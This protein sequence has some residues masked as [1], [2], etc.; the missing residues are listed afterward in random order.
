M[1]DVQ[2]YGGPVQA[3][4]A[5]GVLDA[6]EAGLIPKAGVE[7]WAIIAMVWVDPRLRE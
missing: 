7:D 6:V 1:M 3:G 4:I 5:D 2:V